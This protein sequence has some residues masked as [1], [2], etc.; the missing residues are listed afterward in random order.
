MTWLQTDADGNL[1]VEGLSFAQVDEGEFTLARMSLSANQ[2]GI[3]Q[4]TWTTLA[5]D[6]V[7]YDTHGAMANTGSNRID[8]LEDG[9]YRI[10][11]KAYWQPSTN[12]IATAVRVFKNASSTLVIF[13]AEEPTAG[14]TYQPKQCSDTVYLNAGDYLHLQGWWNYGGAP[15]THGVIGTPQGTYLVVEKINV[16]APVNPTETFNVQAFVASG[17]I[18]ATGGSTVTFTGSSGQTL[19][20]PAAVTGLRFNVWNIDSTDTVSVARG[21]G[22]TITDNLTTG[23]TIFNVPAGVKATFEC[24]SAGV[25]H[26]SYTTTVTKAGGFIP[27]G[28][29]GNR[30]V[31]GLG[32]RPK[33]LVFGLTNAPN[34]A[35]SRTHFGM[36]DAF[37][38]QRTESTLA[39]G[40]DTNMYGSSSNCISTVSTAATPT[41]LASFVSMDVDGFTLNFSLNSGQNWSYIATA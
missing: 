26:A 41:D 37:G 13:E 15:A 39:V 24:M 1:K 3:S 33:S 2:T 20:L 31:T 10:H 38:T 14:F 25:W 12:A 7:D 17:N 30:S 8:I 21:G 4:N 29:T 28:G 18:S 23:A 35:A 5:L 34:G 40:A 9:Y 6:V 16:L 19:T 27:A 36:A 11:G 22:D 32:F